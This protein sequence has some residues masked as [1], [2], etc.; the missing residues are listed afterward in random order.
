[1][2]EGRG[3]SI[4]KGVSIP[5]WLAKLG[6]WTFALA[7]VAVSAFAFYSHRTISGMEDNSL[8]L[9]ILKSQNAGK[10]IQIESVN[11]RIQDLEWQVEVLSAREQ[12]L[13][14]LTREY[15]IQLGLP[16]NSK[17]AEVW[18]ALV[19]T[20]AW[21]WGGKEAGQGGVDRKAPKATTGATSTVEVLRGLHRDLDK[22][23][24]SAAT[25]E[26]ALSELS[27]ALEGSQ[28]L[29]AV[30]PYANPVPNGKVS[31]LFGYRSSPFGGGGVD[32]HQGLDLAAPIGTMV[33]APADG[34]VLSSDWS[35][36]GYGLMVTL[37][38]GFGLTTRYAHLSES[39]VTPGQKVKRGEG[40][41]KVGSTGRS[42]GPHLH[43]ET[44]LGE[45]AVD[46]FNFVRA[47]LEYQVPSLKLKVE[48]REGN[49]DSTPPKTTA[50]L[51]AKKASPKGGAEGPA[52]LQE[53][54][55]K[56]P[57]LSAS[58][59]NAPK[60]TPSAGKGGSTSQKAP[61]AATKSGKKG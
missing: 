44:V 56:A 14:L 7:I 6:L 8:E 28:A 49:G 9:Q 32:L 22:L 1:M 58:K 21:T 37:D 4:V 13:A 43:Y 5:V 40:L 12:E 16:D 48:D 60:G 39:L 34:T 31:S 42:T 33:Y 57:P 17:L 36:S 30:T 35:K 2:T 29:L 61:L 11:E 47:K 27:A 54:A 51:G 23:T 10:D 15:N 25:T 53:G 24:R 19:N 38:H 41:G 3:P 18:P 55:S 46:P 50:S 52:N 20:V 45:V 59:G 26:M